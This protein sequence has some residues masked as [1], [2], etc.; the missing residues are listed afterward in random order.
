MSQNEM[1]LHFTG[2][3]ASERQELDR[4]AVLDEEAL[5]GGLVGGDRV[6]CR[7]LE[8]FFEMCNGCLC[9]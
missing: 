9:R 1:S 2:S 4:E 6:E 5:R 3:T 7:F 8:G